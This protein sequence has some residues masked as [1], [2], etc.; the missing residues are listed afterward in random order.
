MLTEVGGLELVVGDLAVGRVGG[1]TADGAAENTSAYRART[2]GPGRVSAPPRL[3][4]SLRTARSHR[5]SL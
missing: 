1:T 2:A 3:A 4:R 5:H